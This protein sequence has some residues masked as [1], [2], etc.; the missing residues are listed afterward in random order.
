M[1]VVPL[2]KPGGRCVLSARH[3]KS[4]R[5][6]ERVGLVQKR[7][8]TTLEGSNADG[9]TKSI[10]LFDTVIGRPH[11]GGVRVQ[12]DIFEI[13]QLPSGRCQDTQH[14]HGSSETAECTH[15]S[16]L[17]QRAQE[18]AAQ[19][20]SPSA[21]NAS[22]S[23]GI[24][25]VFNAMG[26]LLT[27]AKRTRLLA[28]KRQWQ[29]IESLLAINRPQLQRPGPFRTLTG[30]PV[31]PMTECHRATITTLASNLALRICLSTHWIRRTGGQLHSKLD[32]TDET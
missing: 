12:Q 27:P 29:Q 6:S 24:H 7:R 32:G 2:V 25:I 18:A 10:W 1:A 5:Q 19:S 22:V 31:C 8:A 13:N 20:R 14:Q 23:G 15:R 9:P 11:P 30:F 3:G 28:A 26:G 17:G 16:L 21:R 4:L